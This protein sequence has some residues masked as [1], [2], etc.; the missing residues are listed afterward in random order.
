MIILYMLR[1][2]PFTAKSA[3][4]SDSTLEQCIFIIYEVFFVAYELRIMFYGIR[5]PMWNVCRKTYSQ[6]QSILTYFVGG[7]LHVY[8][9]I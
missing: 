6:S 1:K 4:L 7:N 3:K 2:R 9:E 5:V 8:T